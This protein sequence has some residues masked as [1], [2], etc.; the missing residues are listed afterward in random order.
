M[1]LITG[2]GKVAVNLDDASF[3]YKA[4]MGENTLT[5]YFSSAEHIEI[6]VGSYVDYEGERYTLYKPQNLVKNGRRKHDYTLILESYAALAKKWK[7]R[8]PVDKK[9][10]FS[11]TATPRQHLELLVDCLND[12]EGGWSVGSCIDSVHITVSYNHNYIYDAVASLA[13]KCKT[14]FDFTNKVVSLCKLEYNKENPLPLSYGKGNGFKSGVGRTTGETPVEV[15]LVQGTDRNINPS[16]YGSSTLLLPKSQRLTYE[17]RV[18]ATDETG[19]AVYRADKP[20]KNGREDSLDL[21]E[22]YPSRV[23]TVSSVITVDAEKN[24]F[25]F[26]DDSIPDSL[27][28]EKYLIAGESMTVIFQN[29]ALVTREFEVKYIHDEV[30]VKGEI[31]PGRRFEIVPAEIDGVTMPGGVMVP[32]VGDSYVVFGMQLPDEYIC[33]N[34]TKTGA[35]WDM[36]REA[37]RYLFEHESLEFEFKGTLDNIWSK[38]RWLEIGGKIKLGGYI[39][40]SDEEF[41]PEGVDIRITGMKTYINNPYKPEIEL[42][43]AVVGGSLSSDLNKPSQNEVLIEDNYKASL[44]FTKRRFRDAR[45]TMEMLED[46]L[47]NFS[48]SINPIAVQTMQMLVG[49]ESLQFRFVNSKTNPVA[50]AHVI[51]YDEETMVLTVPAGIL[52]HMTLG[53]SNVSKTHA[54]SEYKYWDMALYNSPALNVPEKKYYLYAKVSKSNSSGTFLL[55]ETAIAMEHV[56]GYYHLLVGILNSEYDGT[57]SFVTLYGFTEI[58]PG[59]ITTDKIVSTDGKTYFDLVQGIIGGNIKIMAGS[60]GL[61]NFEEYEVLSNQISELNKSIEETDDAVDN[62]E[63]Y[64]DG[65]FA[66]GIIS[67]AEAKAIEKYIN[68]VNNTKAGVEA[69]YTKLYAN[70]YLTGTPKTNLLNA[71]I[72]LFGAIDDLLTAI[73]NAISDGVTTTAEKNTVDSKFTA[74]NT[75]LSSFNTAV[76]AAN[77][78]I[79]DTLKGYSDENKA[80]L[81]VL[82][83]QISAQVTR[84]DTINNTIESAGWITKADGNTWWASKTLEDGNTLVSYIN[85]TAT[86]TTISSSKINLTGAVTYSMLNN[87]LKDILDGKANSS[88]LGTL[89]TKSSVDWNSLASSLQSTLNS[90]AVL[91]DLGSL[92]SL[93]NVAWSNLASTLKSTI[94]EK[95]VS[96]D[97]GSLAFLDSVT[98]SELS[99]ALK[100]TI[101]AKLESS[102]LGS[103]ASKDTVTMQD[104]ATALQDVINSKIEASYLDNDII[105]FARLG[106]TIV[107]GGYIK[108]SLLNVIKIAAVE[109]TIAG[110]NISNNSITSDDGA[111]DGGSNA[112]ALTNTHFHLYAQGNSNAYLGYS[113]TNV[114][115]EL[116]L[117]TYNGSSSQKI[118]CDLRDTEAAGYVYTK[119]GLYVD[120]YNTYNAQELAYNSSVTSNFGATAIYINRGHVTG[121]KRHMRH[122]SGN[123]TSYMHKDDSLVNF[124]N[125]SKTT[126]YLPTGCEDGQEIWVFPWNTDVVVKTQGTQ[127]FHGGG[128]GSEHTCSA[129][130]Y[131][132]FI[133]CAY[134]G[135]WTVA[136]LRV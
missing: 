78:A 25:D 46:A 118:M 41:Q 61:D 72:T 126:A 60:T 93:D 19:T 109:G 45:E 58:L 133:Y 4:V 52:Q 74:F 101:N 37:A 73:N 84:I 56:A 1:E 67:E 33:D 127:E 29:G 38:R 96:S 77:K 66:D 21:T 92:A 27:D 112:S 76:E 88:D 94:N 90:Y 87:T 117:N 2:T 30:T 125:T 80:E 65:A 3:R 7:V 39:R 122:I 36:F 98:T 108:T 70:A 14:E 5:L 12:H 13:E 115:A 64:I 6:P 91:D 24:F 132:I 130:C 128:S 42:S 99:T 22:I 59:R 48:G 97:L 10:K 26:T 16:K 123:S 129:K 43:S 68:T 102:D 110:L 17:G 53:I 75:A 136:W 18:Y 111:Y 23:G 79:Q 105:T 15:V 35:S 54:A 113:G 82:S 49:D 81:E 103:L 89:A 95:L 100:N 31:K 8:N 124:H 83:N 120:I 47:L 106:S 57:R 116:G 50:V 55:S 32:A 40:F 69:T 71:K 119:I 134:N 20:L 34:D 104:L 9:L 63:I 62:L 131:H 121:L 28:F 44:E 11:Y 107:E 86:T 135:K 51:T 114:R 85:Q